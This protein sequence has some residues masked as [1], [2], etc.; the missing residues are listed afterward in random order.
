MSH[1]TRLELPILAVFLLALA[2]CS[3]VEQRTARSEVTPALEE[4]CRLTGLQQAGPIKS[5]KR[6]EV[7]YPAY[8]VLVDLRSKQGVRLYRVSLDSEKDL[9]RFMP[10][11]NEWEDESVGLGY[12]TLGASHLRPMLTK[13]AGQFL[14]AKG[15]ARFGAPTIQKQGTRYLVTY[16]TIS[17]EEQKEIR[18][19]KDVI[20]IIDP[21]I[22][23]LISPTGEVLGSFFG[24]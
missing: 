10:E 8:I 2:S 23:V 20:I 19:R 11:N 3:T 7:D 5:V 4:L 16:E 17:A 9:V 6:L 15:W 18:E 13:R 12:D 24:A 1:P 21:Y 14:D 22:S